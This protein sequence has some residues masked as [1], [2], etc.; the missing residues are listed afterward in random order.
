MFNDKYQNLL[1]QVQSVT[2]KQIIS[3]MLVALFRRYKDI[4]HMNRNKFIYALC[5]DKCQ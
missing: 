4:I 3:L 2:V 5:V 1:M